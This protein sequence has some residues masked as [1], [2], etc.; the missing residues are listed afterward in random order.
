MHVPVAGRK[1]AAK[2]AAVI[3]KPLNCGQHPLDLLYGLLS[4]C[5][6]GQGQV[7][8]VATLRV[9]FVQPSRAD[10][11]LRSRHA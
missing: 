9:N 1:G 2:V 7:M 3:H 8:V 4:S 11:L 6:H 5:G 10:S